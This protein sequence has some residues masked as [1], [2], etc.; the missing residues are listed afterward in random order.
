MIHSAADRFLPFAFALTICA[1]F[2]DC[3][4]CAVR[5]A[6]WAPSGMNPAVVRVAVAERGGAAYGSGSLV[7]VDDTAGLILTN[8]HVVRDAAGPI[9]V[10]F[11]DGFRSGAYLLRTDPDWDLAALAVRRPPNARPI[12]IA[13]EAPRPGDL[14]TLIGYGSGAYRAATGR[15][16]QYGSPGGNHPFEM[17]EMSAPARNGDSGGPI[18]NARGELVGVLFGS[19]FGR[20]TGS[21]CGRLRGFV[22]SVAADF[23]RISN[24]AMLADRARRAA[25]DNAS[26]RLVSAAGDSSRRSETEAPTPSSAMEV[27]AMDSAAPSTE[28]EVVARGPASSATE[29]AASSPAASPWMA[30]STLPQPLPVAEMP[31][32]GSVKKEAACAIPGSIAS[33][34]PRATMPVEEQ[35]KTLLAIVGVVAV[36]YR[37]LRLL[38]AALG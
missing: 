8:W 10:Q 14:L 18:L 6:A 37:F 7:A 25:A 24:Q 27:A 20:T 9:V 3:D 26:L 12:P 11:P 32:S 1:G 31:A 4:E 38:G 13:L 29:E 15:C 30:R 28:K 21:Y 22:A 5:A 34:P 17:I 2:S 35:I 19:A 23:Q 33:A 16:T 36:L